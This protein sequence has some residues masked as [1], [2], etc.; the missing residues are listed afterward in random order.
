MADTSVDN[1]H[2]VSFSPKEYVHQKVFGKNYFWLSYSNFHAKY[3]KNGLKM[4]KLTIFG[5]PYMADMADLSAEIF[6]SLFLDKIPCAEKFF[7]GKN[8]FSARYMNFGKNP[9][10]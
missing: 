3:C 5:V 8:I 4:A 10:K 6:F 2:G 9:R 1:L 7:L